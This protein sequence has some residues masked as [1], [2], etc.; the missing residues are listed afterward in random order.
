MTILYDEYLIKNNYNLGLKTIQISKRVQKIEN[1]SFIIKIMVR[2]FTKTTIW[3]ATFYDYPLLLFL[4]TLPLLYTNV[5]GLYDAVSKR[6][7]LNIYNKS[8]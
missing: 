8:C 1:M 3:F 6:H 2:D 5:S 7:N 4:K